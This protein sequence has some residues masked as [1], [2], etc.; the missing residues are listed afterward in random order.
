MITSQWKL[1]IQIRLADIW[2]M[3]TWEDTTSPN[4][5]LVYVKPTESVEF[6]NKKLVGTEIEIYKMH[7]L[8]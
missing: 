4:S 1:S 6:D 2:N 5:P 8:I 7:S 3:D